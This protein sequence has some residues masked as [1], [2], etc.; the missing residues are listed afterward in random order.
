VKSTIIGA[1]VLILSFGMQ[2]AGLVFAIWF[3]KTIWNFV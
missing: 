1:F 3:I 2:L